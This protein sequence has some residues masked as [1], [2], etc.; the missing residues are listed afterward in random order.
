MENKLRTINT[1]NRV[2]RKPNVTM[3]CSHGMSINIMIKYNKFNF[4][5]I[6]C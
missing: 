4:T 3:M 2:H 1:V 6:H 5:F